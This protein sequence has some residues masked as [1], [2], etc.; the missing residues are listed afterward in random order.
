MLAT[1]LTLQFVTAHVPLNARLLEVGCGD[2]EL[3][4]AL[5]RAGHRVVAIDS[6]AESEV[7]ARTRGV[8]ARHA[9]FGDRNVALPGVDAVPFTRSHQVERVPY[10]YRYVDR[11]GDRHAPLAA[12]VRD[13]EQCAID[14]AAIRPLGLRWVARREGAHRP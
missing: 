6:D 3:A 14:A 11:L 4:A 10:F 12:A 2:G 8:D 7:R 9:D 13:L 5:Q 1:S